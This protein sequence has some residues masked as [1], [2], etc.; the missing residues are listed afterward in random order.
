ME[1]LDSTD[2][3]LEIFWIDSIMVNVVD[4]ICNND[5]KNNLN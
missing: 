4:V 2:I 1:I 5:K 3:V